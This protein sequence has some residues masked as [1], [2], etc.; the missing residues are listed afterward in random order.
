MVLAATAAA[1]GS[2]GGDGGRVF[3]KTRS[4]A[5]ERGQER[6]WVDLSLDPTDMERVVW[7]DMKA[8]KRDLAAAERAVR[9]ASAQVWVRATESRGRT[10]ADPAWLKWAE[11]P[12]LVSKP[13]DLG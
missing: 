11:G 13:V 8:A 3:R 2:N 4:S 12:L 6:P 7:R 5:I 1:S 9:E 10:D